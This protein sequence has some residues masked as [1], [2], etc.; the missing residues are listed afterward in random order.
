MLVAAPLSCC[1]QD[2]APMLEARYAHMAEAALPE[3]DPQTF[4]AWRA[5]MQLRLR[6]QLNSS[7]TQLGQSKN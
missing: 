3:R 7:Q 1:V 4:D 5:E 2:D 6:Q